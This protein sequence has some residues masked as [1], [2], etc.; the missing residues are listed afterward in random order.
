[1]EK[2][3]VIFGTYNTAEDGLWTLAGWTLSDPEYQSSM[4]EVPGRDGPLDLS[5]A[6]T[7]GEPRYNGRTLTVS[8]ES[9]E[10][11]RLEREQRISTMVNALDGWSMN[12]EL[13]DDPDHYITGRVRVGRN[14]NDM[15][16]AAVTVTAVCGPWRHSVAET[17]IELDAATEE[18]EAVLIN[19]GR[20]TVV[21]TVTISGDDAS[22]SLVYGA[23]SWTLS[24]GLYQLPDLV[25]TSGSAVLSYKGS[26]KVTVAY[27]EAVL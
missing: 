18:Q 25:L 23:Y 1:M 26:G 7:N 4:V 5:A 12:I 21:P 13:P 16:H 15:A 11:T 3:R 20:R 17:I 8:L 22:V 9:S 2:R 24:A 19:A 27:R 6:L 14:Y 10:G